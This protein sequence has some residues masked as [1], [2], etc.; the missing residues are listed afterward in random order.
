[1]SKAFLVGSPLSLP[2]SIAVRFAGRAM[3]LC[4]F[5]PLTPRMSGQ[6]DAFSRTCGLSSSAWFCDV[7]KQPIFVVHAYPDDADA[8]FCQ[9]SGVPTLLLVPAVALGRGPLDEK[10]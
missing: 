5:F 8:I 2:Q 4:C 3:I 6:Q 1:M 9:A 10:V 7:R